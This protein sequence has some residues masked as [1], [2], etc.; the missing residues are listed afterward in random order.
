MRCVSIAAVLAAC[1]ITFPQLVSA[2]DLPVKAQPLPPPAPVYNWT[3]FYAGLNAG[4]AWENTIDNSFTPGACSFLAVACTGAVPVFGAALPPQLNTHPS[5]FIGGGQI[6]YNFQTGAFLWGI[7]TDFQGADVKGNASVTNTVATF[8]GGGPFSFTS[9]GS[10]RIDWFGTLRARVGWLPTNSLLL[11]ATGGLAYGHTESAAAFSGIFGPGL[12]VAG[13][14]ASQSDTLAGWTVGGGLE[15]MF[16]PRWSVKGEYLYYDLGTVNL[17]QSISFA[18]TP[19]SLPNHF[20]F[21]IQSA[22]HFRGNIARLG[23]NYK[24]D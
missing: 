3:G 4:G 20:D 23:V 21:N 12:L 8:I 2:A 1:V 11:Y 19:P 7:E 6:G 18:T 9:T 13:T 14:A 17:N 24:F 10:Q 5:G 15:W 22:A 16:A